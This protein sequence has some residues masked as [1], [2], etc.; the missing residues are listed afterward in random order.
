VYEALSSIKVVLISV[1]I[2]ACVRIGILVLP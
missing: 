2:E 1:G